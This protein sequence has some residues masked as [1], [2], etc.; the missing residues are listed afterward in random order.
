[1]GKKNKH[2]CPPVGAPTWMATFGDLMSLLLVFFVLLISFSTIQEEDYNKAMG[3]L[4]GALGVVTEQS[5]QVSVIWRE[6]VRPMSYFFRFV[7]SGTIVGHK[8]EDKQMLTEDQD[9]PSDL[10]DFSDEL[11]SFVLK[12]G[13]SDS[14][15]IES[16][17]D[18]L[19]IVLP[20]SFLFDEGDMNLRK[21]SDALKLLAKIASLSKKLPYRFSI[22]GHTDDSPIQVS[23]V[24]SNWEMASGRAL[25]VLRQLLSEGVPGDK[26]SATSFGQFKPAA[27][28]DTMKGR[29]LN[30]RV[31]IVMNVSNNEFKEEGY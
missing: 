18:S 16:S 28:N 17:G 29:K 26:L 19:K 1:M 7:R 27:P 12:T 8:E 13:V 30:R 6:H 21:N 10:N 14:V 22:E 15:S 31:E 20:D 23:Q 24:S 2:E 4:Q 5:S 25:S 9:Q 3:S 11:M